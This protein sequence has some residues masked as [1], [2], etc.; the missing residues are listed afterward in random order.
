M[1]GIPDED[2]PDHDPPRP[3]RSFGPVE[4]AEWKRGD[5]VGAGVALGLLAVA[6]LVA[7]SCLLPGEIGWGKDW[8]PSGLERNAAAPSAG[9][10]GFAAGAVLWWASWLVVRQPAHRR[11]TLFARRLQLEDVPSAVREL[12][13]LDPDHLPPHWDP[14]APLAWREY[15]SRLLEAAVVVSELPPTCWLRPYFFR[16]LEQFIPLW[17]DSEDAWLFRQDRM[18][19]EELRDLTRLGKLLRD[20]PDG[21]AILQPYQDYLAALC[22]YTRERDPPRHELLQDLLAL[23]LKRGARR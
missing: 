19:A 6:L 21:V 3:P 14:S 17:V 11:R 18:S 15:P 1:A 2:W 8:H 5:R 22:D 10:W 13:A 23:A 16:R 20:L 9:L 7:A 12:A 4:R